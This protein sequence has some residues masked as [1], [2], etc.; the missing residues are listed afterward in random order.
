MTVH[1][2][3]GAQPTPEQDAIASIEYHAIRGSTAVACFLVL[4]N[5]QVVVGL[6]QRADTPQASVD[7]SLADA[8]S[9]IP[10]ALNARSPHG[11]H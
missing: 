7:A 2:I 5:G 1:H 3:N 9:K 10:A 4:I 6:S 8:E 11:D